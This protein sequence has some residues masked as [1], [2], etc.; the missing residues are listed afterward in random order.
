M[1][2]VFLYSKLRAVRLKDHWFYRRLAIYTIGESAIEMLPVASE[3][4]AAITTKPKIPGR[5]QVMR[6]IRFV[7]LRNSRCGFS[8]LEK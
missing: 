1:I 7:N 4:A 2:G 6:L 5:Y 3:W 8:D